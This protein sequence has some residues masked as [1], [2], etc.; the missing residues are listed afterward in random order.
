ML[1]QPALTEQGAAVS[2]ATPSRNAIVAMINVVA[3]LI[4]TFH[5]HFVIAA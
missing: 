1:P 3:R 4:F 5:Y 2:A